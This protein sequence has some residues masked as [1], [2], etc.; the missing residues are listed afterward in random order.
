MQSVYIKLCP[1]ALWHDYIDAFLIL[2]IYLLIFSVLLRTSN[3]PSVCVFFFA[4]LPV[5][6]HFVSLFLLMGN[7][8]D[9]RTNLIPRAMP[10]LK[11]NEKSQFKENRSK[12]FL[13]TFS[14]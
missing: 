6:S 7:V 1:S 8:S 10:F 14:L 2:L 11:I 12:L 9:V 3:S 5:S 4:L 13:C